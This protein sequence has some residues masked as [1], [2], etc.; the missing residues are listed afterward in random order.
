MQRSPE[1]RVAGAAQRRP[2][3]AQLLKLLFKSTH[4][5]EQQAGMVPPQRFPQALQL[6]VVP[7]VVHT[8]AQ[9]A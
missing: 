8:P 3:A 9:H 1:Q 5:R 6:L 7:S 2:H 4:T